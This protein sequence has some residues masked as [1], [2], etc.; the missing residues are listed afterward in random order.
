MGLVPELDPDFDFD[1]DFDPETGWVNVSGQ[2]AD[3]AD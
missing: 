2:T 1:P 3:N